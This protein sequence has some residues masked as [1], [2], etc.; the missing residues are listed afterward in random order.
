MNTERTTTK[1]SPTDYLLSPYHGRYSGDAPPC[2]TYWTCATDHTTMETVCV[3]GMIDA[4][5]DD[6]PIYMHMTTVKTC[7]FQSKEGQIA[8]LKRKYPGYTFID[9][10]RQKAFLP[11]GTI[12]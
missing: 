12:G 8:A 6:P 9:E 2:W 4:V 10:P 1:K 3:R 7:R 5:C 11:D